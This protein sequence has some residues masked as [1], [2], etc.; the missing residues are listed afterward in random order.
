MLMMCSAS[1]Q[2]II[3][4]IVGDS[5]TFEALPYVTVKIKGQNR[6]TFSDQQGSFTLMASRTDTLVFSMVGYKTLEMPLYDWEPSLMLLAESTTV[7]GAITVQDDVVNPYEGMFD[8]ENE[9]LKKANKKLPFFYSRTK[10]QV[11]KLNRLDDENTRVKTYVDIVINMPETRTRLMEKYQLTES[12]YYN[13][14][15]KFNEK[16]YQIMYYL[17]AGELLSLLNRFFEKNSNIK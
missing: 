6:G 14:L 11:I 4:G 17:T 10:K 8:E 12:Q 16:N 15:G 7:L 5:A 3:K 1:A 9:K 2:E 13:I